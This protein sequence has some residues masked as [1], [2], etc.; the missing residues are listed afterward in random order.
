MDSLHPISLFITFFLIEQLIRNVQALYHVS[1]LSVQCRWKYEVFDLIF[2]QELVCDLSV[3]LRGT[4]EEKL[5]WAFNL[6]DINND[7]QITKEV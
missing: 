3:L 5:N 1:S 7:G 2:L 4:T 6:Y